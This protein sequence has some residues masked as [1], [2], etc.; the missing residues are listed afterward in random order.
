MTSPF[1]RNPIVGIGSSFEILTN[2]I[3]ELVM[4]DIQW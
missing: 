4:S 3:K 1:A 2:D